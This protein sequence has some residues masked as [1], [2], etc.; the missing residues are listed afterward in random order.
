M[1]NFEQYTIIGHL[2][3]DAEMRYTPQGE[4]V[5]SFSVAVSRN[6][7][8][9]AGEWVGQTKWIKVSAWGQLAERTAEL[10]KGQN[11]LVIGRLNGDKD[12]NPRTWQDR[13]GKTRASFEMTA[14][15]VV[16]LDKRE[17][18]EA[19]GESAGEAGDDIPF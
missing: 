10:N 11:V 16:L 13:E 15:R 4:P 5:T 19:A 14:E 12:G 17:Q 18:G 7:K 6:W 8:N 1:A 2:G 3:R 9:E